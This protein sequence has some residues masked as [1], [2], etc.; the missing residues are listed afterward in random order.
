VNGARCIVIDDRV[1]SG[2]HLS[3]RTSDYYTQ[4]A[5]GNVWYFGEDTAE[6]DAKGRAAQSNPRLSAAPGYAQHCCHPLKSVL[7]GLKS[8]M[9]LMGRKA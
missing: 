1:Y 7:Q 5:K 8:K 6:L 2:G 9:L 4:D 3:E